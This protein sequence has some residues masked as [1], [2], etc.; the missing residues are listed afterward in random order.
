MKPFCQEG[1]C[2]FVIQ[3][4]VV[5]LN[6]LLHE[7]PGH[8]ERNTKLIGLDFFMVNSSGGVSVSPE[9]Q[10]AINKEL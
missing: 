4:E 8:Q 6:F 10:M 1:D 7:A 5:L 9:C 3:I 2:F